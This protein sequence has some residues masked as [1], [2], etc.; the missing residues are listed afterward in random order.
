MIERWLPIVVGLAMMT[1]SCAAGSDGRD[2]DTSLDPVV[3]AGA[4]GDGPQPPTSA[5]YEL[6]VAGDPFGAAD[7]RC[8]QLIVDD[9]EIESIAALPVGHGLAQRLQRLSH[10]AAGSG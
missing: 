6:R 9:N 8:L 5:D 3:R 2:W 1:A 7:A 10:V 4:L